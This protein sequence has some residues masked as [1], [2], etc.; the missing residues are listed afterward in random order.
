MRWKIVWGILA[1]LIAASAGAAHFVAAQ[2]TESVSYVRSVELEGK[3]AQIE[4]MLPVDVVYAADTGSMRPTFDDDVLIVAEPE[5]LAVGDI[6]VYEGGEDLI[7][8]RIVGIEFSDGQ[9]MYRLKG[10]NNFWDDGLIPESVIKWK[11]I[12]ILY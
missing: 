11:V 1:A 5:N 10:D 7:V 8:H 3:S 4:F 2:Q 9:P 6:I 12:G